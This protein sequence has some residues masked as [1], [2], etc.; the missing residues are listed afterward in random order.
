MPI[1]KVE[2]VER[3]GGLKYVSHEYFMFT[4]R[5]EYVFMHMFTPEKL[6]MMGSDLITNVYLELS[7]SVNVRELI[8]TF[9][10]DG[11]SEADE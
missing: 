5:M 9:D 8:C 7:A 11:C 2:R 6:V 1:Q 10:Y 4:L 3:F